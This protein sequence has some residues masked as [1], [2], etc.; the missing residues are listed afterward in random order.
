MDARDKVFEPDD[1]LTFTAM[2]YPVEDQG[3]AD[4]A[5]GLCFIEEFALM[6]WSA[7]RVRGLFRSG[8]F[9]GTHGILE[10]QGQAFVDA[11]VAETFEVP[12]RDGD[13]IDLGGDRS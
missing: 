9:A 10:R 13:G 2:G 8:S 6:G 4:R 1:P 12:Q 3:E 5:M 7:E 11:L